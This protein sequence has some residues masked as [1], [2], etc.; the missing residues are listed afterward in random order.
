MRQAP[1][2]NH[3]ISSSIVHSSPQKKKPTTC[4][5]QK[6]RTLP[7]TTPSLLSFSSPSSFSSYSSSSDEVEARVNWLVPPIIC[8]EDEED[9]MTTNLRVGFHERRCK[10]LFEPI[11]IDLS[12]LKKACLALGPDSPSKPTPLPPTATTR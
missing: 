8:E 11:A 4:L 9:E 12:P 5:V 2:T 6:A 1:T 7:P 10:R 3:S